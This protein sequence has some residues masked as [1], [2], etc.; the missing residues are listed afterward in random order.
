[1]NGFKLF[2]QFMA[3]YFVAQV[4]KWLTLFFLFSLV[5]SPF[6]LFQNDLTQKELAE[7][8]L[9]RRG[10][11]K[12]WMHNKQVIRL[13][14]GNVFPVSKT[15]YGRLN[16]DRSKN[17]PSASNAMFLSS[18]YKK[19]PRSYDQMY[20]GWG[21]A[22]RGLKRSLARVYDQGMNEAKKRGI[23]SLKFKAMD[24]S[25]VKD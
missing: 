10:F 18:H 19:N 4:S 7:M 9:P 24:L 1:M 12:A 13:I 17:L 15:A 16:G 23:S 6:T 8:S 11:E 21:R 3:A 22:A 2:N 25:D 5:I 20:K 14:V